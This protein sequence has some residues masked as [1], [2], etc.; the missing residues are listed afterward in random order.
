MATTKKT[1][2]AEETVDTKKALVKQTP[3]EMEPWEKGLA[4]DATKEVADTATG[5]A[6]IS[7]KGGRLSVDGQ[8]VEGNKLPL[9]VISFRASKAYYE[10]DFDPDTPATPVCY[11]FSNDGSSTGMI[12]HD[13]APKKQSDSCDTCEH[14]Q[15]GTAERGRGKRCKDEIRAGVIVETTDPDT[16]QAAE[17]RQITIP[18]GSLKNWGKYLQGL[19]DVTASGNVRTVLTEVSTQPFGGAYALTFKAT[20]KL[21]REQVESLLTRKGTVHDMLGQPY[22]VISA[23]D[24]EDRK[25][26]A[27]TAARKA[28]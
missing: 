5:M 2:A 11:A 25:K 20:H 8:M 6:R 24:A 18:P 10:G 26:A 22:P 27:K 15:F 16:I 3:G 19:K 17:V 13:A 1:K 12:P 4:E 21:A 9:A 7:H 14:N 23:E 28:R